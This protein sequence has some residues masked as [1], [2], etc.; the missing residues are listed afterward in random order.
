MKSSN[1]LRLAAAIDFVL[2]AAAVGT[3]FLRSRVGLLLACAVAVAIAS[4][5]AVLLVIAKRI[6]R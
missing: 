1:V 5:A 2:A 3:P 6:D 4:G